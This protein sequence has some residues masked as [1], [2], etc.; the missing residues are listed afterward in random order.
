RLGRLPPDPRPYAGPPILEAAPF[1]RRDRAGRRFLLFLP[2][3]ARA[4][5]A[6]FRLRPRGDARLARPPYRARSSGGADL[7]RPRPRILENRAA[8]ASGADLSYRRL[9]DIEPEI[10]DRGAVGDPAGGDQVD[11]GGGDR[12]R[13]FA[14]DAAR[15]L[16]HRAAI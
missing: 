9:S 13:A 14:G 4:S 2:H 10:E 12:R 11:P 5:V 3:L 7:F 6:A 8:G 15:G 1:G 16:G